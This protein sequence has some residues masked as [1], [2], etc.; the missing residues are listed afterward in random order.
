[1]RQACW[2]FYVTGITIAA[3]LAAGL[4]FFL[5]P[6]P[7]SL[8]FSLTALALCILGVAMAVRRYRVLTS[9]SR[10][11][12]MVCPECGLTGS[13]RIQIRSGTWT[14]HDDTRGGVVLRLP[15]MVC[16]SPICDFIK[17]P[18]GYLMT[19]LPGDEE[20]PGSAEEM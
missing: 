6:Q 10:I 19:A 4:A 16:T 7:I 9:T 18:S 14:L 13:V 2:N 12:D 1:M 15:L 5:I 8:V 17:L 3:G 20:R 11:G